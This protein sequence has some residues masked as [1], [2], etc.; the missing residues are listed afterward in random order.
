MNTKQKEIT[1]FLKS[2]KSER[3]TFFVGYDVI[4]SNHNNVV[5]IKNKKT[6]LGLAGYKKSKRIGKY[7]NVKESFI[8]IKKEHQGKGLG[9]K[10]LLKLLSVFKRRKDGILIAEIL[11]KN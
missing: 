2:L 7:L 1:G 3:K 8:V 4:L 6:I 9:K 10:L 5:T 11:T